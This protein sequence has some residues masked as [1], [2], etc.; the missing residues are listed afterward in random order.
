[1]RLLSRTAILVP[2]VALLAACAPPPPVPVDVAEAQCVQQVLG[3]AAG[4]SAVTVGVGTGNGGWGWGG[5]WGGAWGGGGGWGGAGVAMTTTLP[6][7]RNPE[8]VYT[9]CVMRKSG[10]PPDTPLSQ[11]PEI[12]G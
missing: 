7:T 12:R 3:N 2:G 5:G 1:M 8:T 10:Q 6:D 4:N 11:R 9:S